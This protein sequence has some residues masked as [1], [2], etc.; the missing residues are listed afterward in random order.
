MKPLSYLKEESEVR[1]GGY[2]YASTLQR[3]KKVWFAPAEV[4]VM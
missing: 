1:A 3:A 4:L 2:A